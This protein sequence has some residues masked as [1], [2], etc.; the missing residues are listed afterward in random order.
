MLGNRGHH[1][2]DHLRVTVEGRKLLLVKDYFY[3]MGFQLVDY[4]LCDNGISCK[5]GYRLNQDGINLP[6]VGIIEHPCKFRSVFSH[7]RFSLVCIHS[8]KVPVRYGPDVG[9]VVFL[10]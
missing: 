2:K 10:L 9:F 8:H 5:S 7:T 6:S 3:I 4:I 1:V